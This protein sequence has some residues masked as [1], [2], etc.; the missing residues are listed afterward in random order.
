M[1]I[2]ENHFTTREAISDFLSGQCRTTFS[3][4]RLLG[5]LADYQFQVYGDN[6]LLIMARRR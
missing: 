3:N 6:L 1:W 2:V 4:R 5:G